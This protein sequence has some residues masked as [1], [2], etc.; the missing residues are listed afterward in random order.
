MGFQLFDVHKINFNNTEE[1]IVSRDRRNILPMVWKELNRLAKTKINPGVLFGAT[2]SV[3]AV[4]LTFYYGE[5]TLANLREEKERYDSRKYPMILE[6]ELGEKKMQRDEVRKQIMQKLVDQ[7][8]IDKEK[9]KMKNREK[10]EQDRRAREKEII[11]NQEKL[12]KE[13]RAEEKERQKKRQKRQKLIERRKGN[14][15]GRW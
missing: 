14:G 1:F 9:E 13:R 10:L 6:S 7:E 11:K 3:I 2:I 8:I 15:W 5:Q 4:S 12:E